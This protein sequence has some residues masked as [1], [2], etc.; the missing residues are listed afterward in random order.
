M[1]TLREMRATAEREAERIEST[2]K[3]LVETGGRA[4]PDHGELSRAQAFAAIVRLIDCIYTDDV[5]L[6]RTLYIMSK[7]GGR[8]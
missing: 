3:R 7:G 1:T 4:A 5:M 2:Q 6:E 8:G